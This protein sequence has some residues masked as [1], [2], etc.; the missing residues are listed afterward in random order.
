MAAASRG[1]VLSHWD[2]EAEHGSPR[3]MRGRKYYWPADPA[4]QGTVWHGHRRDVAREHQET[5]QPSDEDAMAP[6]DRLLVSAGQ[7]TQRITVDGLPTKH[8]ATL[9][10]AVQPKR[11]LPDAGDERPYVLRVGG[12]KPLGLGSLTATDVTVSL[13]SAAERYGPGRQVLDDVPLTEDLRHDLESHGQLSG[14]LHALALV[15]DPDALDEKGYAAH[16]WYP[17]GARWGSVGKKEFDESFEFFGRSS[18]VMTT[19]RQPFRPLPHLPG[20]GE[21]FDPTLEIE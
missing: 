14:H 1:D 5:Q 16:V 19:A 8:V 13:Q 18:G 20:E 21:D 7:F 2:S 9:L 12:G 3:R 10:A 6:Q 17:P 15:L 11:V 4:K